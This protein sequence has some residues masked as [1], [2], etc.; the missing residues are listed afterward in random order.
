MAQGL[1]C[2]DR[3]TPLGHMGCNTKSGFAGASEHVLQGKHPETDPDNQKFE[4]GIPFLLVAGQ[5]LTPTNHR[6]YIWALEGI[7][8]T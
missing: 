4:D 2:Q 3:R 5:H 1:R 6:L 7:T 8:H